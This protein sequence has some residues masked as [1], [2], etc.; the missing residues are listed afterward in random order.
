MISISDAFVAVK[1]S[2]SEGSTNNRGP[3]ARPAGASGKLLL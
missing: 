3:G 2:H 1:P